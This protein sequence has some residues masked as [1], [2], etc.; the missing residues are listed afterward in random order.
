MLI[1]CCICVAHMTTVKKARKN[2]VN[3]CFDMIDNFLHQTCDQY[4]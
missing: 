1:F 2:I 4:S 3:Y